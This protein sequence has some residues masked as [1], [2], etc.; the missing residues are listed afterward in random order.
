MGIIMFG[1]NISILLVRFL[2]MQLSN[3][4]II[5]SEIYDKTIKIINIVKYIIVLFS[6]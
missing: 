2:S 3:L 4:Y 1:K 6:K 5:F